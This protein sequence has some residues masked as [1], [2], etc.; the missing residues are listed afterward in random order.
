MYMSLATSS[1]FLE[2]FETL[3]YLFQKN[4]KKGSIVPEHQTD[5]A[6]AL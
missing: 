2:L 1:Y 5:F 3:K 4:S 6:E